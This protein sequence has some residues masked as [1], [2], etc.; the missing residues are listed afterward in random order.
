MR[1]NVHISTMVM[2]VVTDNLFNVNSMCSPY[3]PCTYIQMGI[4]RPRH[5]TIDLHA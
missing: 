5:D 3:S 1:L 4:K 2:A